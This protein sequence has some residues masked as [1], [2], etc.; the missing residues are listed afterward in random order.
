[1]FSLWER[2]TILSIPRKY[3]TLEGT[4][5]KL[6]TTDNVGENA[7]SLPTKLLVIGPGVVRST[8]WVN[9]LKLFSLVIL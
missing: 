8:K 9:T 3:E 7:P 5:T 2:L 4:N 1:M 6:G